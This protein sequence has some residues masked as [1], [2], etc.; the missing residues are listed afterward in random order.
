MNSRVLVGLLGG[1]CGC[2]WLKRDRSVIALFKAAVRF[3]AFNCLS[4]GCSDCEP[5]SEV[6]ELFGVDRI[7][8][9]E[10]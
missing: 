9:S 6:G 8:S 5:L 1:G 10:E 4:S 3:L 2:T 7:Q